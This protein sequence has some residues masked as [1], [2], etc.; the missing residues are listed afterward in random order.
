MALINKNN[1]DWAEKGEPEFDWWANY[2][3]DPEWKDIEKQLS[4]ISESLK[5]NEKLFRK[6]VFMDYPAPDT[7][8]SDQS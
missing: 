3:L 5:K 6:L 2:D 7:K 1:R 4:N 8:K